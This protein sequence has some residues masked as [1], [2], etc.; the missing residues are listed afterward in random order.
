MESSIFATLCD[1]ADDFERTVRDLPSGP[2]RDRL[3]DLVQRF[4]A[5]IDRTIGVEEV[6][7][8]HE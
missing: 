6:L 1:L 2:I 8:S 7:Q 5:V 3:E 4:D